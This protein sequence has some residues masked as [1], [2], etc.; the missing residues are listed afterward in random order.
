MG[1]E[2]KKK[3]DYSSAWAEARKIVWNARWRLA[4]GSVLMLI[5]RLAGMVL[6]ASTKYIGD[7]VFAKG[8]YALIKWIALA[9]GVST[10]I[11][12]LTGFALSQ[13]LGVAAQRAITEMRKRVQKRIE[14]LPKIGRAHV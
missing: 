4:F 8:N 14:R 1:K 10:L 12:G 3:V 9:I 2:G 5:S 7:E 13:V 11:Q 6:P